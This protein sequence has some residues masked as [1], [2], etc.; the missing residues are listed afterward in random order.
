M[1]F[2]A[3]LF[4]SFGLA[5]FPRPK[6]ADFVFDLAPRFYVFILGYLFIAN[7]RIIN[8]VNK[9]RD[10]A[11]FFELDQHIYPDRGSTVWSLVYGR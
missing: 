7:A 10:H 5:H 6:L 1:G 9:F 4:L 3:N 11:T 2:A 8:Y